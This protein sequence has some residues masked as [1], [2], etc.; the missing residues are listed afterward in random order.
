MVRRAALICPALLL[1]ASCGCVRETTAG[2]ARVF[3]YELWLPIV[4]LLGGVI[5]TI[6]GVLLRQIWSRFAWS[7]IVV[8]LLATL[9]FAPSLFRDRAVLDDSS[10]SLRTGI[11]GMTAV[12]HVR[13]EDLA[14]VRVAAEEK[15]GRRGSTRTNYYMYCERK[16]GT[17][18]KVPLGN[19]VAAAGAQHF[20]DAVKSR[21][22][23]LLDER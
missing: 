6:A 11:W 22:I 23:P 7:L 12:H 3:S 4:V 14:R 10:Y 5:G 19:R 17:T 18:S 2:G 16:N 9:L 8:G 20:L 15:R 1:M 13:F 21:G